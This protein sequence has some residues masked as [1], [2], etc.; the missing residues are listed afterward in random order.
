MPNC[1]LF[2]P[3]DNDYE[4][5]DIIYDDVVIKSTQLAQ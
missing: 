3:I 5:V 2:I 1:P 4:I